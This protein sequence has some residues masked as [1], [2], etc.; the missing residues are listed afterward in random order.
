MEAGPGIQFEG[1]VQILAGLSV[2]DAVRRPLP[3]KGELFAQLEM[4]IFRP[5]IQFPGNRVVFLVCNRL[6]V[7]SFQAELKVKGVFRVRSL[8]VFHLIEGDPGEPEGY[9]QVEEAE[10]SVLRKNRDQCAQVPGKFREPGLFLFRGWPVSGCGVR[11]I[12]QAYYRNKC[13]SK[14]KGKHG[15]SPCNAGLLRGKE[16]KGP[17][18]VREAFS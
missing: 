5:V 11:A 12:Q 7:F 1:D 9:V 17:Q 4:D 16:Q 14:S 15:P 6:A 3:L 18:P 2:F 10:R 8:P 13:S